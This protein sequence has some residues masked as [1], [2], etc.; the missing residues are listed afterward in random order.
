LR[1]HGTR[2][3]TIIEVAVVLAIVAILV[4]LGYPLASRARPRAELAGLGTEIHAL[5][6]RARQEALARGK[7]VAV[8]FYPTAATRFGQGRI[9][10]IADE[11]GGFM[12]GAAPAGNIDYCTATPSL[13]GER[14]G[15]IDLP[16]GVTLSVPARA[17]AFPFPYNL[18]PA[19]VGG[20]SFCSGTV[21]G[22]GGPRG[23][24][25]FDSRGRAAF[26]ADCGIPSELP[27]GGSVAI[28]NND[29]GGSRVL[30]VLPSGGIRTFSVE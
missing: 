29:L 2:G 18:V 1:R 28:T 17:Q 16:A 14:L 20:C 12:A 19:P 21:P 26:Y 25:R 8:I 30:A 10:A 3:F 13:N 27:N 22:G 5:M 6:H 7:D 15:G 11:P 24:V 4:A 23:A 9:L